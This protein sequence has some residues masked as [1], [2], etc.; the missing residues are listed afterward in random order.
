MVKNSSEI[1]QTVVILNTEKD[2][3]REGG[4]MLQ[5]IYTILFRE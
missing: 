4:K 5:S 2:G 1:K 3:R